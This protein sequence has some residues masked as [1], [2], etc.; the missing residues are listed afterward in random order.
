MGAPV[1]RGGLKLQG[2]MAVPSDGLLAMR[3]EAVS[4]GPADLV[5][6]TTLDHAENPGFFGVGRA[7]P[8]DAVSVAVPGQPE[9][10]PA[11]IFTHHHAEGGAAAEFGLRVPKGSRQD[12]SGTVYRWS[13]PVTALFAVSAGS[14]TGPVDLTVGPLLLSVDDESLVERTSL[15]GPNATTVRLDTVAATYAYSVNLGAAARSGMAVERYPVTNTLRIAARRLPIGFAV[16]VDPG[17]PKPADADPD[18]AGRSPTAMITVHW[19][20]DGSD[21]RQLVDLDIGRVRRGS[22][23]GGLRRECAGFSRGGGHGM[24]LTGPTPAMWRMMGGPT[25]E[26]LPSVTLCLSRPIF[27]IPG[28]WTF[29]FDRP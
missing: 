28:P 20:D 8:Y 3:L 12:R 16:V 23:W 13:L 26:V 6:F 17:E 27:Q 10:H 15:N 24:P 22:L 25:D 19:A 14:G 4:I 21:G 9:L 29:R 1:D 5:S 18:W 2:W 11:A 7:D